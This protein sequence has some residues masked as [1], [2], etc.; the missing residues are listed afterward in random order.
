MENKIFKMEKTKEIV[1]ICKKINTF[2]DEPIIDSGRE[3][4]DYLQKLD[5]VRDEALKVLNE[6]PVF[7]EAIEWAKKRLPYCEKDNFSIEPDYELHSLIEK[8]FEISKSITAK[9]N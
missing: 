9:K 1:E 8:L 7:S 3:K 5:A 4:Y 2:L 6:A